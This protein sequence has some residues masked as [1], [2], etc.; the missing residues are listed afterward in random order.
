MEKVY[1]VQGLNSRGIVSVHK[2]FEGAIDE[3]HLRHPFATDFAIDDWEV[4]FIDGNNKYEIE[5]FDLLP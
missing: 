2:T 3:I 1:I 4:V 5:V